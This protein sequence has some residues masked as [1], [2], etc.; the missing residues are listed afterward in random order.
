M[1]HL[2]FWGEGLVFSEKNPCSDFLT[3]NN[4]AKWHSEKNLSV[5]NIVTQTHLSSCFRRQNPTFSSGERNLLTNLNCIKMPERHVKIY[6][7]T[8]CS[9]VLSSSYILYTLYSYFTI[10][11]TNIMSKQFFNM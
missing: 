10:R 1:D 8:P 4:F 5:S 9:L 11:M 7:Q 6:F 3:S 2:I